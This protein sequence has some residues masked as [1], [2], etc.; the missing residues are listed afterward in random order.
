MRF[1]VLRTN[2]LSKIDFGWIVNFLQGRKGIFNLVK[3]TRYGF[4][5]KKGK[6]LVLVIEKRRNVGKILK[7]TCY[8][9]EIIIIE[10]LET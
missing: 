4:L 1:V 2:F 5:G 10:G 8:F 7:D 3:G 9:C 6:I